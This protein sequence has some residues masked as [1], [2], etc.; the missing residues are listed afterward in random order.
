MI[1]CIV[2]QTRKGIFVET[3]PYICVF[4][5]SYQ[6]LHVHCTQKLLHVHVCIEYAS[7]GRGCDKT[8]K[9]SLPL[10]TLALLRGTCRLRGVTSRHR[11]SAI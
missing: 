10:K 8:D 3:V 6:D 11:N 2:I 9:E 4:L 7:R 5:I 1:T